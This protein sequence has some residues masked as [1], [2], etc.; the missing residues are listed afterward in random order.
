[1]A[2]SF[3]WLNSAD[4]TSVWLLQH[5]CAR[6]NLKVAGYV[7][8]NSSSTASSNKAL[9]RAPPSALPIPWDI[10]T[11]KGKAQARDIIFWTI[12]GLYS[13]TPGALQRGRRAH[14]TPT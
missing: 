3:E 13:A 14:R 2:S 8:F 4:I 7:Y 6:D 5:Y 1:M 12:F 11:I 10:P 9:V